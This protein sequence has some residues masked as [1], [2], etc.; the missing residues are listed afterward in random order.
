MVSVKV[1]REEGRGVMAC[2]GDKGSRA[3][4]LRNQ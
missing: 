3:E 4:V 2:V 1:F